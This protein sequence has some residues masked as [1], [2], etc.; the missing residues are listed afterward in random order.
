MTATRT[1]GRPRASRG[2]WASLG[3]TLGSAVGAVRRLLV[4]Q[5]RPGA[6]GK[7][8][9]LPRLVG[10]RRRLVSEVGALEAELEKL[11]TTIT[12][13]PMPS[14]GEAGRSNLEAL[15]RRARRLREQVREKRDTLARLERHIARER[16]LDTES[17]R[18][19][20]ARNK[21]T[22]TPLVARSKT[23]RRG[24]VDTILERSPFQ[25]LT[26]RATLRRLGEDL[27]NPSVETRHAACQELAR[28]RVPAARKL[29]VT[30]LDDTSERVQLAALN[31]LSGA[32]GRGAAHAFRRFVGHANPALRLSAL[33]GLTGAGLGAVTRADVTRALSDDD[34]AVRKFALRVLAWRRD[35]GARDTTALPELAL[36]LHDDDPAVRLGAVEALAATGSDRA[37]AALIRALADEADKVRNAASTAIR[38]IVGPEADKVGEGLPPA[39]RAAALKQWWATAR[40]DIALQRSGKPDRVPMPEIP[41][42]PPAAPPPAE[43]AHAAPAPPAAEEPPPPQAPVEASVAEDLAAQ[44]AAADVGADADTAAA[45]Q[46]DALSSG[47]PADFESVFGEE[48]TAAS[49]TG[50]AVEGPG[51]FESVFGDEAAEETPPEKDKK[52]EEDES[53]EGEE[54]E[55]VFGSDEE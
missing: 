16:W 28:F 43:E 24:R 2:R 22:R 37:V 14:A 35:K 36:A 55:N 49:L 41:V 40:I 3:V 7:D 48:T 39:D 47:E 30:A 15:I 32:R 9:A 4:T 51:E 12:N 1:E 42:P 50:L 31:A 25:S 45:E 11:H 44:V 23:R 17:S 38:E 19:K 18:P 34:P 13:N 21:P 54:Y 26:Q 8:V 27:S 6:A 33:R 46:L 5:R 52:A 20:V 10:M 29:L 53:T